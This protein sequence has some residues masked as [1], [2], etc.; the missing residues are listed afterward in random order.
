MLA[1]HTGSERSERLP[2]LDLQVHGPLHLRRSG[3]ADDAPGAEGPGPVLHPSLKPSDHLVGVEDLRHPVHELRLVVHQVVTGSDGVQE[4]SDRFVVVGRSEEG[5]PLGVP[6]RHLARLSHHVVP[7]QQGRSQGAPRV[8]R[9]GLD[10]DL[11]EGALPEQSAVGDAV[12]RDAPGHDKSLRA[13]QP[14]DVVGRLQHDLFAHRLDRGGQVHLFLPDR[15]LRRPGRGAEKV[16]ESLRRHGHALEVGKVRH[17]E[18]QGSVVSNLHH[19]LENL[20]PIEGAAVGGK[21]HQ[22]VLA[23]VHL[24]PGVV[25]EGGVEHPERMREALLLGQLETAAP[26]VADRR[27]GPLPDRVEGQDRRLFVRRREEGARRVRLVMLGEDDPAPEGVSER[28]ADHPG[29]VELTL[30]PLGQRFPEHGEARRGVP[31]K[32]IEQPLELDERFL[33][34]RY[35]VEFFRADTRSLQTI[36][37]GPG[38]EVRILLFSGEPLLLGCRHD[39]SVAEKSRGGVM[40]KCGDSQDV[41]AHPA[42]PCPEYMPSN[43]VCAA[44]SPLLKAS[45]VQW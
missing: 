10:P 5:T 41:R 3:V 27:G 21:P 37:H 36:L 24:E 19:V 6:G 44:P 33:V 18:P 17:I 20:V 16:M 11:V 15:A 7:G 22:F 13:R 29:K 25:R 42:T 26:P 2:V 23:G 35:N 28:G 43:T 31:R 9:G 34:E 45:S 39:L 32:R 14:L 8:A 12:Q 4:E 40:V 1:E 38:R 30:G